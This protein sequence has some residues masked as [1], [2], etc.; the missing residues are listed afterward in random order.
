MGK[1]IVR[2]TERGLL[3]KNG[4]ATKWLEPGAHTWWGWG[5]SVSLQLIDLTAGYTKWSPELE[6]LVP[7]G[8]AERLHVTRDEIAILLVDGVPTRTLEPGKYLLWNTYK[9]VEAERFSTTP[10]FSDMPQAYWDVVPDSIMKTVHVY[11]YMKELV[12]IDGK[13]EAILEQGRYAIYLKGKHVCNTWKDLREQELQVVGQEVMSLDKATLRVNLLVKYAIT[14]IQLCHES[15]SNLHDSLYSEAQM[16]ARAFVGGM[17]VDA[18]LESKGQLSDD[19]HKALQERAE[20]WGVKVH[21]FAIKDIVLPGEMK[22]LFNKV[23][24]A[25]KAAAANLI[26]RREETAATRSLANTAKMLEKNPMLLR[27][28]EYEH[29]KEIAGSI[30]Q[31]HVVANA[32]DLIGSILPSLQEK[33][34]SS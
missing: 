7:E 24:Q 26:L 12:Y 3:V 31:L 17:S 33:H 34:R 10:V 25:E 21:R 18:L 28:K 30:Q 2:E 9:D 27:L 13:L 14:D 11:P 20:G 23:I 5:S 16:I 4:V 8:E 32:Q 29:L 6:R 19:M 1:G 22:L 15:V